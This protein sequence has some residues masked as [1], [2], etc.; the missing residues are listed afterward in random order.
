MS[1]T[2]DYSD[3]AYSPW[4]NGN[5]PACPHQHPPTAQEWRDGR[6]EGCEPA[7][8]EPGAQAEPDAGRLFG[9]PRA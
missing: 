4:C 1:T 2:I 6:R 5:C 3:H 8:R 9:E 7:P